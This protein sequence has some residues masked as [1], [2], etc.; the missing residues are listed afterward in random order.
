MAAVLKKIKNETKYFDSLNGKKAIEKAIEIIEKHG[1]TL[2]KEEF[3][4]IWND[5][6][7]RGREDEQKYSIGIDSNCENFIKNNY[8]E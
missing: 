4:K 1:I 7:I 3:I 8:N 2:E 6:Y 5:G